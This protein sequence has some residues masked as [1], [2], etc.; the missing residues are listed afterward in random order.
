MTGW[1][2]LFLATLAIYELGRFL[3]LGRLRALF[4]RRAVRFVREHRVQLESARFIDR[5]WMREKLALDPAIDRAVFEASRRDDEPAALV[6]QRVDAYVDEIA[7]Y[8]SMASYYSW[9]QIVAKRVVGFLFDSSSWTPMP[10]TAK[11]PACPRTPCAS[12]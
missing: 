5:V 11:R 10:S 3:L 9:A 2:C 7:P 6:R 4:R 12:T 1:V 8:F